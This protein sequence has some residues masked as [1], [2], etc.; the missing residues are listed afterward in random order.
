MDR[1]RIN[2]I[3]TDLDDTIWN[4][5]D[6]WYLS[7]NNFV[8]NISKET[9]ID[10]KKLN[11]SFKLVHQKYESSEFSFAIRELDLLSE[12]QINALENDTKEHISAMHQYYRDLKETLSLYEGVHDTLIYLKAR[13]TRLIGFTESNSFF[14]K[15]RLKK[16]GLD[17]IF[18]TVYCPEDKGLPKS[19][20]RYYP[21][22]HWELN[23]TKIKEY[24]RE[25]RK[26]NPEIL[27]KILLDF[28]LDL[29]KTIY[30]GDKLA[31]DISMANSIGIIS[32]Y[33][34]FGDKSGD[35]RY[36]LL[37]EVTHWSEKEVQKEIDTNLAAKADETPTYSLQCF[38]ELLLHFEFVSISE[39]YKNEDTKNLIDIWKTVVDVQKHFNDIEIRVRSLAIT[40]FTFLIGGIGYST[41]ENI[42]LE[43]FSL[44]IPVSAVVSTIAIIVMLAFYLMDRHWYHNFLH[45][46]VQ[47]GIDIE[48]EIQNI[49]PNIKLTEGIKKTSPLS[50]LANKLQIHSNGK[51]RIFYFLL[52]LPFIVIIIACILG[53]FIE[54]GTAEKE[55]MMQLIKII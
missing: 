32:C 1:L 19:V 25:I 50:L 38:N 17:G 54:G 6:T 41:K 47:Q 14:T 31:K 35:S 7:F 20:K 10:Q 18:D 51:I 49:Y 55:S 40:I 8:T 13:G 34:K 27:Q 12:K 5:F 46:S 37:R 11:E 44:R 28:N 9:G 3:I 33:A 39:S 24:S 52:M 21:K 15:K 30:I 26:P 16:L 4:W 36:D 23:R 45:S 53:H 29:A 48:K 2:C 42:I 43:I 22:E